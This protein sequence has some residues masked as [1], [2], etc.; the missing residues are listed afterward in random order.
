MT[1]IKIFHLTQQTFHL[2]FIP[3]W[4]SLQM[5]PDLTQTFCSLSRPA[6]AKVFH[7]LNQHIWTWTQ[8]SKYQAFLFK[9]SGS[10]VVML[11]CKLKSGGGGLG[12]QPSLYMEHFLRPAGRLRTFLFQTA[13]WRGEQN[14]FKDEHTARRMFT[15][16]E[17]IISSV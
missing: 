8:I 17:S 15:T 2:P 6:Q 3:L 11:G 13:P 1:D 5:R 12:L 16:H 4:K 10:Q 14:L 9:Y 7:Y